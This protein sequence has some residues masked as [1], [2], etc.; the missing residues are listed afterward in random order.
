MSRHQ[1]PEIVEVQPMKRKFQLAVYLLYNQNV[2][3]DV[4]CWIK[5]VD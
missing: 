4:Y 3:D 1:P 5:K 2:D